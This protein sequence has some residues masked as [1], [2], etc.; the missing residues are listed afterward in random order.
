LTVLRVAMS[1]VA[2]IRQQVGTDIV[3]SRTL[4]LNRD[5]K[6]IKKVIGISK[7]EGDTKD[8]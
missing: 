1:L 2:G 3:L 4:F 8:M 6:L 7:Y 5:V